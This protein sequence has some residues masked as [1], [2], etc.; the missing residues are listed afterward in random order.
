MLFKKANG[1]TINVDM[2]KATPLIPYPSS[3]AE[4]VLSKFTDAE[5]ESMLRWAR[6]QKPADGAVNLACWPGWR[7]AC[8]RLN[9]DAGRAREVT[10]ALFARLA[11]PASL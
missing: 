11:G 5:L 6:E 8:E 2:S 3:H 9:L 1:E 7:G 4:S 10:D